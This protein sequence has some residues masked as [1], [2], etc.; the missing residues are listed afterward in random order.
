ME[1]TQYKFIDL[2]DPNKG[3][4]KGPFGGDIKKEYFVPKG[5]N[6][7]KVYEQGV[8]YNKDYTIGNYYINEDRFKKLKR[9]EVLPKDIL[10]SGAGTIGELYELPEGIEQGIINQALIRIRIN[11]KIVDREYFK[12]YFT[13]YIKIVACKHVGASVIPNL[14]PLEDLKKIDVSIP[15]LNT[16]KKIAKH[17]NEIE[18]KI[19]LNYQI[20]NEL[21]TVTKEL[22]EFWFIQFDFPNEK[23]KPYKSYGGKMINNS[24][25]KQEIPDGW[26]VKELKTCLNHINTGLNPRDNFKLGKGNI[27]YITVKNLTTDGV[28]DFSGCD[29]IDDE[30][31]S[32]VHERSQIAK[33]DILFASISP[34]GRCYIIQEKPKDWDINE[35]V[36]AISPNQKIISPE[37]LYCYL[38][39]QWFKKK[40]ER[41]A[42]GS[43]F[44]GIRMASINAMPIII[45]DERIMNEITNNL[46]P[47]FL[48]K[49]KLFKEIQQLTQL[50]DE[51]LPLLMNGQVE[52]K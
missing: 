39:S 51:L 25:L 23:N 44:S 48:Q 29:L 36:F 5:K 33:G 43:I 6:T 37:Y 8:V 24:I 13:W 49:D 30:A 31:C 1:F 20:I 15:D 26:K 47:I 19:E 11:E 42:T 45:P 2:L 52:V 10:I 38:T 14:P 32:I 46:K 18:K 9:F 28:I 22:Y 50:R 7:Y 34:L 4:I 17:L 12:Y 41:E 40:A 35:S 21:E 27:K 16:Q 3:I